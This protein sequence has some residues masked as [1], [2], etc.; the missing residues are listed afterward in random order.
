M[1]DKF[2]EWDKKEIWSKL[3][4]KS[5][6]LVQVSRHKSKYPY[7]GVV[8]NKWCVYAYIYPDHPHFKA[9]HG[10]DIFQDAA[11]R[12]P[13]HGGPSF[14]EYHERKG[15]VTSIQVGCDYSHLHDDIYMRHETP[16]EAIRVFKDADILFTWLSEMKNESE[17]AK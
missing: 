10:S 1:N 5:G 3:S 16:E 15:E 14:L 12:M 4:Y 17:A 6:F 8:E 9:F 13:L 11:S 2:M 7:K